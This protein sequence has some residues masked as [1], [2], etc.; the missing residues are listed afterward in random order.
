M[1]EVDKKSN[2]TPTGRF[3][4]KILRTR[5]WHIIYGPNKNKAWF[6]SKLNQPTQSTSVRRIPVA[7]SARKS[8][9]IV[10]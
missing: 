3:Y 7:K 6:L 2:A 8:S 4:K 10:D 1:K 9:F 5:T